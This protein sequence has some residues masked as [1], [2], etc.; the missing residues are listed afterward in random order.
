MSLRELTQERIEKMDEQAQ[1]LSGEL[2]RAARKAELPFSVR[3]VGS[4]I[5]LFFANEAPPPTISRDDAREIGNFH[6]AALT[7]GLFL[8]PR[9]MIALS[10]VVTDEVL[11][12]VCERAAEAMADV[13]KS[14]D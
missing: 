13:A 9:G 8:A 6:L 14:A 12:E 4:L 1:R 7:H 5:N 10:T 11:S 2:A 3:Q